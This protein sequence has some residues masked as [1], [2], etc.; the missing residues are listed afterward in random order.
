V[1]RPLS[2]DD[3]EAIKRQRTPEAHRSAAAELMAWVEERHPHD[4]VT[5]ADLLVSAAWHLG[6]AGDI[7]PSLDL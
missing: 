4:E 6:Q 7:E 3:V 1:R 5:P 2:F